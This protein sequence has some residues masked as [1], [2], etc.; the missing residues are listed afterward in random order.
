MAVTDQNI[1]DGIAFDEENEALILEIYDHLNFEG[2]FEFDHL[3]ILQDKLNTYLWYVNS[4]QY[5]EV[6]PNKS[7]KKFI[8]NIHF[9]F[10]ITENCQKYIEQSNLKLKSSNVQIISYHKSN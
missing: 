2:K 8:I 9:K 7:F 6:Y 1:I 3:V 5:E 10:N 4:N